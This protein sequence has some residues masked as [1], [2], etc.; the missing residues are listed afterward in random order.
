MAKRDYYDVLGVARNATNDQI[1]SAYRKLARKWHPDVNKASDAATR[2]KEASEAYEAL[3][4]PQKRKLYDQF[5]HAGMASGFGAGPGP[6]AGGPGRGQA[7]QWGTGPRQGGINFEDIFGGGQG[8]AGMSLDDIMEALGGGRRAGAGRRGRAPGPMQP[9]S[10]DIEHH[11]NL[12]FLQAIHGT[13]ISLRMQLE[14]G[15]ETISVR[16]PPGVHE[17]ARVRVR[18]KGVG[19]GD[20]FIITHVGPHPYF[21]REGDDIYVD[22][23]IGITEAVLGG[24]IDVP[25]LEGISTVTVPP[26]SGS[27]R[28][29]RLREK[30]VHRPG[31]KGRGDEY[32]VLKIAVPSEVPA[33][34]AELLRQFDQL[35][36][37]DPRASVPWKR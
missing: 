32:V 26:G 28:N 22:V 1:K 10:Q 2:F 17:G 35:V 36:Q 31:G 7:Y 23:P 29:L 13:T 15:E 20:L 6:S 5:G 12:D 21:R 37:F 3:S 34:A 9:T 4:D 8:F 14:S 11:V 19:G 27:G 16:I 18:G 30:G 25:T 33:K 24:K